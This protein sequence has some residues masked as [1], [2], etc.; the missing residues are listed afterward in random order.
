MT[1]TLFLRWANACA[2]FVSV[3]IAG[4]ATA[5][6]APPQRIRYQARLTDSAGVPLV[7]TH[8]LAF[9]IFAVPSGGTA[10]WSEGPVSL[11]ITG[12]DADRLLGEG[13]PLPSTLFTGSERWLEVTVDGSVLLPRQKLASVPYAHA[14]D[15]LGDRTISE[16]LDRA[17]HTGAQ[18][19]ATISPQG[20]GS[21][22]NADT[23]DDFD[24]GIFVKTNGTV[25]MEAALDMGGNNINKA[26]DIDGLADQL[27]LSVNNSEKVRITDSG[28]VGIGTNSPVEK[29]DVS[30]SVRATALA[31]TQTVGA[32]GTPQM[33]TLYTDNLIRAWALIGSSNQ[34]DGGF[35]LSASHLAEGLYQ[36]TFRTPLTSLNYAVLV[37]CFD[38]QELNIGHFTAQTMTGFLVQIRTKNGDPADA[39]HS[40]LVLG[41]Q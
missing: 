14:A 9:A 8:S 3:A 39:G 18:S 32:T 21:G 38:F 26:V 30:G 4:T 24:S 10:L 1:S 20:S 16:V 33:N 6:T 11:A 7:G 29:L 2:L 12:G 22:L 36:Y 31:P 25:P 17:N 35:N 40:V 37:T 23:I 41:P 15:R 34:L 5:Q 28:N 27:T 19:P 13:T